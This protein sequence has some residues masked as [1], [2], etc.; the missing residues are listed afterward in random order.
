MI[1]RAT[2]TRSP[3]VE[4]WWCPIRTSIACGGYEAGDATLAA[5]V[6]EEQWPAVSTVSGE[7]SVPV[8]WKTTPKK[9][10]A[11]AGYSSG[12]A[13]VPPTIAED[14][15]AESPREAQVSAHT[16]VRRRK[17]SM[18]RPTRHAARTCGLGLGA[19]SA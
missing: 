4:F 9:I 6:I 15:A 10:C 7:M 3:P 11:T 13:F 16:R 17:R 1:T 12:E 18:R 19:R 2:G 8:H 14:G 5:P